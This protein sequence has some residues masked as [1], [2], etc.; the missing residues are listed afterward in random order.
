M[1]TTARLD[2]ESAARFRER[3][4]ASLAENEQRR[5]IGRFYPLL[6]TREPKY[7]YSEGSMVQ[8]DGAS[9]TSF[10]LAA[11]LLG[12]KQAARPHELPERTQQRCLHLFVLRV[13]P[14]AFSVR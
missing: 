12:A 10:K 3:R 1:A 7:E 2:A 8:G 13:E 9:G 14:L 4:E 6:L 11:E 5:H